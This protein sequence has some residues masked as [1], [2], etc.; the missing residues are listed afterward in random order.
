MLW[1]HP[2]EPKSFVVPIHKMKQIHFMRHQLTTQLSDHLPFEVLEAGFD[3]NTFDV[4]YRPI[5]FQVK[6]ATQQTFLIE[7]ARMKDKPAKAGPKSTGPSI[8][9]QD[10]ITKCNLEIESEFLLPSQPGSAK[11]QSSNNKGK[12]KNEDADLAL[13]M[14]VAAI[15]GF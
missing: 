7:A 1:A 4:L 10:Y 3:D 6:R 5:F 15:N 11:K 2:K 14:L 13:E 12:V 8:T 9:V